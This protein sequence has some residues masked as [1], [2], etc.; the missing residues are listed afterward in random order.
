[1]LL[2]SSCANSLQGIIEDAKQATVTV[3]TFDEYG[4]PMGK[5]SAFFIDKDG[6]AITNY[7]VLNGATKA[8]V[9]TADNKEFEIDS[10]ICSNREKDIVKFAIKNPS[11]EKF[12]YLKLSDQEP[13]Q[14]DKIYNISAPMGLEH[15]LSDGMIS[16][17]RNDS[18]GEI[19][20]VT[21]PISEG[22]SG[23]ALINEEG[24]VV[25][26]ATFLI[27]GGQSLNFGV[28]L[29]D[30]ILA[31]IT[32]N[33]FAKRNS[34]FNS[35][36]NFIIINTSASNTPNVRLNAIEF[37]KQA[38]VAYFSITNLDLTNQQIPLYL[39]LNGEDKGMYI[40]DVASGKKYYISSSNLG[41]TRND[42]DTVNIA[43]T[44]QFKVFFPP[45]KNAE[46][47]TEIEI[48]DKSKGWTFE[49]INL[50]ECRNSLRYDMSSFHK[51]YAYE[52]MN[53]GDLDTS[54][55][56]FAQILDENPEDADALNALGIIA[57]VQGNKKD[58]MD[59]FTQAIETNP[60][61][62]VGYNNRACL[63]IDESQVDKALSDLKKSIGINPSGDNYMKRAYLYLSL[64]KWEEADKDLS[65]VLKT[66]RFKDDPIVIANKAICAMHLGRRQEAINQF[67]RAYKLTDDPE[68]ERQIEYYYN[69]L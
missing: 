14:G 6:T 67:Q 44:K 48:A 43:T 15:T 60:T 51:N 29:T 1:M 2:V 5:G 46:K 16:A 11:G 36:D 8:T 38:T 39:T 9:K 17:I 58:A 62:E 23:S 47:L 50:A 24:E 22:S 13:K 10:I 41:S 65:Q 3:Y 52:R 18:H 21:T 64:A 59:L 4:A 35:Q 25:A 42:A 20:Q 63:Y 33:D 53:E 27:K 32:E 49:N 31:L 56:I 55:G 45:V 57:Y 54:S 12:E 26:V 66:E 68:L 30:D 28:R 19:I 7:H 40:R 37:K 34:K 69:F 61:S